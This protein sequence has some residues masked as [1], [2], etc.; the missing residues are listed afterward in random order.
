MIL[1]L[2]TLGVD[3][4]LGEWKVALLETVMKNGRRKA[5]FMIGNRDGTIIVSGLFRGSY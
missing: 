3:R 1:N 2:I 5:L 4:E